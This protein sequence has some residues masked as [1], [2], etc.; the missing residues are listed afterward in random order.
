MAALRAESTH[1]N[2]S[3]RATDRE[4]VAAY[5]AQS[6]ASIMAVKP[7]SASEYLESKWVTWSES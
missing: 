1:F 7:K 3:D 6:N 2:R 5:M 4:T